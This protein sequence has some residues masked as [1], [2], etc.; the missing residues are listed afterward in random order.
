MKKFL[1]GIMTEDEYHEAVTASSTECMKCARCCIET[2]IME[3]DKRAGEQCRYLTPDLLCSIYADSARPDS[4]KEFPYILN[5]KELCLCE[6]DMR[7]KLKVCPLLEV[8][9]RNLD[10][11]KERNFNRKAYQVRR[12]ERHGTYVG[13][14]GE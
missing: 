7:A 12:K 14:H 10:K 3:L 9:W 11:I 5:Y 13:D 2:E 8:F 4:C 6:F 1:E